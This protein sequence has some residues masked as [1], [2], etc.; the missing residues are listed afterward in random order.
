MGVVLAAGVRGI[1]LI[2]EH[3]LIRHIEG[4]EQGRRIAHNNLRMDVRIKA[5]LDFFREILC[6]LPRA[7][8][9][10]K[11]FGLAVIDHG[12]AQAVPKGDH[13]PEALI[14]ALHP[15]P[16]AIYEKEGSGIRGKH[17][18]PPLEVNR[19]AGRKV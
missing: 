17:L 14:L 5:H 8:N 18:K 12:N 3:A 15:A 19:R 13:A 16:D 10:A 2:I 4:S 9:N 7:A 1:L 11:V 6:R